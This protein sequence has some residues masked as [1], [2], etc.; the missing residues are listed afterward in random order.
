MAK[1]RRNTVSDHTGNQEMRSGDS[2]AFC[3]LRELRPSADV[4]LGLGHPRVTPGSRK[5]HPSVTQGRPKGRFE[6]V[7]LFAANVEK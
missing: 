6:K 2:V 4:G 7:P 5:G 3:V 1:K